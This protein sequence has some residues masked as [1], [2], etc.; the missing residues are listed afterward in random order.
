[1]R[2]TECRTGLKKLVTVRGLEPA[3]GKKITNDKYSFDWKEAKKEADVYKLS[4]N[5]DGNILGL[6]ALVDIPSDKRIEI[7]LLASSVENVGKD[8]VY[9]GIAG[10]L[11]SFA[12]RV[13]VTRYGEFACVS[14]LPK[15]ELKHHY[16]RKY[17]MLDGEDRSILRAVSYLI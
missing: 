4:L 6:V 3:D 8:K 15:T 12:C 11:I 1:M 9:E 17:G 10:N 2:V 13:A 7:K 16:M 5:E 14:L